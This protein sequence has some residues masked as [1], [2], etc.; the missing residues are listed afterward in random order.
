[1]K[2]ILLHYTSVAMDTTSSRGNDLYTYMFS[3]VKQVTKSCMSFDCIVYS[4]SMDQN[5]FIKQR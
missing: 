1:M 5:V 3:L 2:W 4:K